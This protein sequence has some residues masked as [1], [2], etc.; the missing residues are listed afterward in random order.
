MNRIFFLQPTNLTLTREKEFLKQFSKRKII[1]EAE[2]GKKSLLDSTTSSHKE[3]KLGAYV[4]IKE[5]KKER[6]KKRN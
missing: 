6:K 5:K 2:C 3:D 4:C 1:N